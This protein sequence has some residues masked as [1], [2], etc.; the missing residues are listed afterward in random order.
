IF[1][2]DALTN[3][4][5]NLLCGVYKIETGRR[6]GNEPQCSFVS[7]FPKPAAWETSGLNIG[8]WSSDCKSWYQGRLNEINS[9]NPVLWT[10]NQWR[11]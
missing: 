8:F 10:T 2:D 5:I 1:W 11:H 6:N 7:W 3:D 9:P 4:K